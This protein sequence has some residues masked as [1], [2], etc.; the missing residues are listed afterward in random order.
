MPRSLVSAAL[1]TLLLMWNYGKESTAVD[2]VVAVVVTPTI[3]SLGPKE[4]RQVGC[5]RSARERRH[6]PAHGDIL[7]VR[8]RGGCK[9]SQ[10]GVVTA[11]GDGTLQVSCDRATANGTRSEPGIWLTTEECCAV[12]QGASFFRADSLRSTKVWSTC[13]LVARRVC[14]IPESYSQ[15]RSLV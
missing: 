6:S 11:T 10:A 3:I 2:P 13:L 12:S 9:G 8:Q 5:N 14:P 1:L 7:V 4:R 15:I